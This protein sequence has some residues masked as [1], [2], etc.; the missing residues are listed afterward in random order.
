MIM[1][2][3]AESFDFSGKAI[4]PV[5]TYAV[6]GLGATMETYADLTKGGRLTNGLAVRGETARRAEPQVRAWLRRIKLA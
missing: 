2:T 3:F 4:H 1:S 6:S 5:V